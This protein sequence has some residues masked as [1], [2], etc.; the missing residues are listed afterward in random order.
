[1]GDGGDLLRR[2]EDG[3]INAAQFCEQAPGAL[4]ALL[5][6]L[7]AGGDYA[8]TAKELAV[9]VVSLRSQLAAAQAEITHQR[10]TFMQCNDE[11]VA[12]KGQLDA[13]RTA[14]TAAQEIGQAWRGSWADF[15][16]RTLRDEMN[17]LSLIADGSMS[18]ER[19][20]ASNSLCP[21]GS[22]HWT[23]FCHEE[24]AA[25]ALSEEPTKGFVAN[26]IVVSLSEEPTP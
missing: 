16:G 9:E 3:E 10:V 15:D 14:L 2:W 22:G 26:E 6:A 20:R 24:C 25:A 11:I 7:C 4:R 12:L 18:I 8:A 5:A 13:A 17:E 1:M 21:A 23:E 19:Y